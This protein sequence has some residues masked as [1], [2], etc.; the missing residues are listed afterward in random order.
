MGAA[1]RVLGFAAVAEALSCGRSGAPALGGRTRSLGGRPRRGLAGVRPI[2]FAGLGHRFDG[3]SR[4]RTKAEPGEDRGWPLSVLIFGGAALAEGLEREAARPEL[5]SRLSVP[6]SSNERVSWPA[7]SVRTSWCSTSIGAGRGSWREAVLDDPQMEPAPLIV[8]GTFDTPQSAADLVALGAT[9]VLPKPVS[10]DTLRRTVLEASQLLSP[11]RGLREPLGEITVEGLAERIAAEVR[12]GLIDAVEPLGRE[13]KVGLGEGTDVLAAVW[14]SVARVRE[15]VTLRSGGAVRFDAAGPEGA[16]PLAPWSAGER[17]AGERGTRDARDGDRVSLEGRTALVA[18]DDP[19]V[20]WF[21]GGLLRAVGTQSVEAH[22]GR[23][24]LELAYETWPDLVVSDLLM[25]GL[26]GFSLCREIKRDV[27]IR[28]VP[29]IVLSWK[30][31]LLQRMRELGADADG[32]LRKEASASTVVQRVREVLRPRARVE[33]RLKAGGEVRGR[34]DGLTPRLVLQLTCAHRPDARVSIRDAVYLYEVQVR[35]GRPRCAT[36]TA[37]DGGFERGEGVLGALLGASAGRF[38][39]TPD[40]SACRRDFEGTLEQVLKGP[41]GRARAAQHAL[42]AERFVRVERVE[43]DEA[44]ILAYVAS[45]PEP[46]RSVVQ[47]LLQGAAPRELVVSGEVSPRLLDLVL[48]DIARH[49]AVLAV[50]GADGVGP[51]GSSDGRAHAEAATGALGRPHRPLPTP[52]AV[53]DAAVPGSDR[54]ERHQR[55]GGCSRG[56]DLRP[57]CD[58]AAAPRRPPTG[59]Y[60]HGRP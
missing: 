34:L 44:A 56:D 26:D 6:R 53:H 35:E 4:L 55:G 9:R 2:A 57:A 27:A 11:R 40:R 46:A 49:G 50:E 25:P 32:Y 1:A 48:G 13:T 36:R 3:S 15:L 47:Q 42:A 31:D 37:A 14:A 19:A 29:V 7:S 39:V 22:D 28:D 41:I 30:E 60:V 51:V 12:R 20:V 54:S 21:I 59:R 16:I 18:D 33:A 58:A 24:A 45:T 43:I 17:G 23:R 52:A 10:P 5:R 38:V 8:V